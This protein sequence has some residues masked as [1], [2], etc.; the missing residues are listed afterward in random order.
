MPMLIYMYILRRIFSG[1]YILVI[2]TI[3]LLMQCLYDGKSFY[4]VVLSN[5]FYISI[6][7]LGLRSSIL[8]TT[9]ADYVN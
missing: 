5:F 7:K 8:P 3:V 6:N 4:V 9:S 2:H 1:L